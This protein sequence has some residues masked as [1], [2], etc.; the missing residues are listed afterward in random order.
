MACLLLLDQLTNAHTEEGA[1]LSCWSLVVVGVC[2]CVCVCV[3]ELLMPDM[4][5]GYILPCI[6][7]SYKGICP[8]H[9]S[10]ALTYQL[11]LS[12]LKGQMAWNLD[13][14]L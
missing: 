7:Q 2:M 3:C 10:G 13:L 11:D 4:D 1:S 8:S 5:I 12:W 6:N 14:T 9:G